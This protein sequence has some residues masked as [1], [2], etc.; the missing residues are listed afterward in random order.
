VN[1]AST[2][3]GEAV[4]TINDS[5][6]PQAS[7]SRTRVGRSSRLDNRRKN[8]TNGGPEGLVPEAEPIDR[9]A[10]VEDLPEFLSAEEFRRYVGLGRST[11]YDLLRRDEIPHVRF[12]RVIRIPKSALQIAGAK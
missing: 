10:R 8:G 3:K 12:G 5:S 7:N 6:T 11:V 4:F 9:R 2:R 1:T